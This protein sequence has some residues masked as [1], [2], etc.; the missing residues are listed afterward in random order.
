MMSLCHDMPF[1]CWH[2]LLWALL[3]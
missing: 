2:Q 1:I 3:Q